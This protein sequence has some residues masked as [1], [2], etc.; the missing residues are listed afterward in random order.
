MVSNGAFKL[1]SH[2]PND[3][4]TAVKNENYWTPPTSRST[5]SSSN[6]SKTQR[7]PFAVSK[8]RN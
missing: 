2:V 7:L 5:K 8:P 1:Q 4:L 3:T 6:R